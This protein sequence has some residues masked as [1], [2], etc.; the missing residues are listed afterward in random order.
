MNS[1]KPISQRKPVFREDRYPPKYIKLSIEEIVRCA[2]QLG[3]S[4]G[5]FQGRRK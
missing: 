1:F 2:E 4:Y 3:I 5:Q